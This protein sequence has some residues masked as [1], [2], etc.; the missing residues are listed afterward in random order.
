MVIVV[1]YVDVAFEL[2]GQHIHRIG[3]L[4]A[5]TAANDKKNR[6]FV[7]DSYLGLVQVFTDLG[8]FLGVVCV[9][10]EKRQFITPVGLYVDND[11]DRLQI[12]EM[13]GNKITVLKMLE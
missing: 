2:G 9:N 7:S 11:A 1:R 13:K 3:R 8:R 6:V 5:G 4:F 10:N 12:V